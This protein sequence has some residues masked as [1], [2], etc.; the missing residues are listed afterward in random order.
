MGEKKKQSRRKLLSR[1]LIMLGSLLIAVALISEAM[2]YPWQILFQ[3]AE[4]LN[5]TQL[6]DP[7]LPDVEFFDARGQDYEAQPYLEEVGDL[8]IEGD[9]YLNFQSAKGLDGSLVLLGNIKIPRLGVTANV[10]EGVGAKALL[11]GIGHVSY[12]PGIGQ[13]GN[14]VLAGHRVARTMH[15]FRHLDK[16]APGDLVVL[17]NG[18]HIFTYTVTANFVV[19]KKDTWVLGET[20]AQYGLT[21]LTCTPL[22]VWNQRII[23]RAELTDVDGLTPAEFYGAKT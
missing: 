15:I 18:D 21:L 14:C 19:G 7:E 12:S 6:A 8:P 22:G 17:S 2:D 9:S 1:V 11:A 13:P 4:T 3:D 16:V 23:V 10:V 5:E 20:D